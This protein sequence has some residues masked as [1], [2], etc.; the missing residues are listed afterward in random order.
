MGMF[1]GSFLCLRRADKSET[2][3][4]LSCCVGGGLMWTCALGAWTHAVSMTWALLVL[5]STG[6]FWE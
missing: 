2:L 1:L 4:Q 3:A 5:G 6:G